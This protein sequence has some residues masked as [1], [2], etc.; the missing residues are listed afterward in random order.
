MELS[1]K[2]SKITKLVQKIYAKYPDYVHFDFTLSTERNGKKR[3]TY[4]I[5]TPE[6]CHNKFYD[7]KRCCD[8]LE[9]IIA[10]GVP[11]VRIRVL[12]QGLESAYSQ[13]AHAEEK[14]KDKEAELKKLTI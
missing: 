1:S 5:Y 7:F 12:K 6:L 4:N 13:K 14:I 8:F 2:L 10:D 9:E 11:E 3:T